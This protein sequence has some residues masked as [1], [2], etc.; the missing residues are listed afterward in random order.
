MIALFFISCNE[1][2]NEKVFVNKTP[3]ELV[4]PF[5][6]TGGHGHTYPGAVLPFGMVQLSPDTR[7]EGWDGCS[8]YHYTDSIIYGFSH[9]H[10]SGTGVSDYGDVLL[11]PTQ[12]KVQFDNGYKTGAENGYASWFN[13]ETEKANPGYYEVKL[14]EHDIDVR[15]T[16]TERVGIH[17]YTF[18]K[19]GQ[20]NIILDLLHRDKAIKHDVKKVND[21]E[22]EGYRISKAWA[23]E[24]HIYFVIQ[25]SEPFK[26]IKFSN[27]NQPQGSLDSSEPTT[28]KTALIYTV[29]PADKIIV[30]VGIS[31]VSIEGA[32]KNLEAEAPHWDFEKYKDDA[33]AKWETAL[34]KI[35]VKG[36]NKDKLAVFYSALYHTMIAP[37]VFSDVT[38]EYR[39][40]DQQIHKTDKTEVYTIFSL[41]DTFR[42]AHPLFTI[43]EQ[44]KTTA[45]INT[46][47]AHYEQGG[48]LPVWELA[49]NETDC[50]IG[51]HSVSVITDA[52]LKGIRGF[53][54]NKALEAMQHS[55]SLDHL[56]LSAYKSKGYIGSGDEP[57]SVSKTLEYAYDDWC[58]AMMSKE[59]GKEEV[60]SDY[61]LRA[62]HFKN[63]FNPLNGFMQSKMNGGWSIGFNPA[64][65][66]FNFTEANSWQ[67]SMFAPQDISGLIKLYGGEDKFEQ[68][69]DDLFSTN[70]ELSG[71]HQVDIT[72]L[73]GQYAHGNEPS[74]HMAYL[75]NYIG[76]PWKTQSRINQILNEQ[77]KN[78][79]EGLSGNE[80]C[81][82]MSA[83]YVLSSMGFYSVTPGLTYY[84][85]GTP[86]F[87]KVT[88]NLENG[89]QFKVVAKNLSDENI[90]IQ[91][92][93]L[94]GKEYNKSFLHHKDIMEGGVI[95]FE[96]GNKPNKNWGVGKNNKPISSID[97]EDE[98]TIVPYFTTVN[99]TFS[100]SL[101]VEIASLCSDCETF[102]KIDDLSYVKY[103]K[104]ITID[105]STLVSAFSI[106]N[107]KKSYEVKSSYKKIKGGRSIVL[108]TGYSNQYSAGGDNALINSLKGNNNYRTGYWQGYNNDV[109][110]IVDLGKIE[111]IK[112]I[113]LGALQDIQSW[114]FYP[115][116]VKISVSIDNINF[117]EVTTIQ[118]SFPDN[119]YG[120][121][122][123]EFVH[124]F[125][126]RKAL[127]YV[128]VEA[129]NYGLCPDWH[130][131]HG[132][133][134]MLFVDE[135]TI[136]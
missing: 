9:T 38:G 15:L 75:Y 105:K 113:S 19:S 47:L 101:N 63:L 102:Y 85:I 108:K 96:M 18:N 33:K 29:S 104:P 120:A 34:N 61:I 6:G 106:R 39:G 8:G 107:G 89:K 74:H 10:L 14:E 109:I 52:F 121:F 132:G 97:V 50:M 59:L 32:R 23:Q 51:Y 116:S 126:S 122:T 111:N 37:N 45:F 64:E 87:N 90:Y 124:E 55:A 99:Q 17:E 62:Q 81:G 58:I 68:K 127:R 65:V 83:W 73:I 110:A 69:L 57:E 48:R 20:T 84:T 12:G 103:E 2:L 26:E 88:I 135:I 118:N 72:G 123:K 25:V 43:I 131:G 46:F 24:Q 86:H 28:A 7:L 129:E 134:T 16:T 42:A 117:E 92:A 71:R 5:I 56:G 54:A 4:D 60:Y 3:F 128:E 41:W 53:D 112:T 77:Y 21:T 36:T 31:A 98:I 79:P 119:E 30:K 22:I 94:N 93:F 80:D 82:Q 35:E 49:A 44:E 95:E 40:M 76:K 67:Y 66:N 11:M 136:E 78:E 91:K 115:K 13:K 130:L 1:T 125:K 27:N 133:Q 70:M 114:I 100:D